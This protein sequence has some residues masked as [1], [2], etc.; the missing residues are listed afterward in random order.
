[1]AFSILA[2]ALGVLLRIFGNGIR[3]VS[4]SEGYTLATLRA[5]SLL[6]RTGIDTP[7]APG[8]EEGTFGKRFHWRRSIQPYRIAM[9]EPQP[10]NSYKVTVEVTWQDHKRTQKVV[11]TTLKL[12]P[13]EQTP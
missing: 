12:A 13:R 6:A 2:I 5:E 11:L 8:D 10:M 3:G 9:P 4:L 1:M 7:L